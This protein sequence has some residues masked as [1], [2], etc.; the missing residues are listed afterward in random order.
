MNA[1]YIQLLKSCK[2]FGKSIAA[3]YILADAVKLKTRCL[4]EVLKRHQI[5]SPM[6][7]KT[8]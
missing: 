4:Y 1:F 2:I 3:K 5:K 6:S 8:N 7:R